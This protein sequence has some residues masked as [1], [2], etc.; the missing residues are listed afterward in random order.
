MVFLNVTI[1]DIRF[2]EMSVDNIEIVSSLRA[3][4]HIFCPQEWLIL[5]K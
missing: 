5:E 3:L 2:V 1:D 4:W